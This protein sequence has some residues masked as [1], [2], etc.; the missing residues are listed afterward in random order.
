[1]KDG[2][3]AFEEAKKIE[4]TLKSLKA[5]LGTKISPARNCKELHL[6]HPKLTTG[7]YAYK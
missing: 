5:P 3:S 4:V 1:M 7:A 6:S 2:K